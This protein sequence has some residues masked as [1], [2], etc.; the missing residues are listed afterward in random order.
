MNNKYAIILITATTFLSAPLC[1]SAQDSRLSVEKRKLLHHEAQSDAY[2]PN[3]YQ[4]KKVTPAYKYRSK[5]ALKGMS[6]T[7]YTAQV[8]VNGS[9]QNIAG[10]AANEPSIA[11]NPLNPA[12]I[13]IGWRQ[14]DNVTSNF[15]QAGWSFTT[16]G[17]ITWT[18]PGVIEPGIFRSDPV[19]DFDAAGNF[20]YNSLTNSPTYMCK[21]FKSTNGGAAWNTGT[22]A[23]GGDKQWMVIDKTL[24]VGS[25]NI[26]SF[27]TSAYSF[28]TPD[29][30]TRSANGNSSYENCTFADGDPWW[31]TMAVNNAGELFIGSGATDFD[32]LLVAKSVNAQTPASVIAWDTMKVYLDGYLNGWINVNPV[33]LLGQ[34]NIDIDRSNGPGQDNIYILA[35]VTRLSNNDEGD[36]M[37]ARSTNGGQTWSPPVKINDDSSPMNTQW[38][39]TMSV[40]PNGR[41]DAAWLDTRDNPGSD[42]SALY[43]SYSTDQGIT[44]SVNEKLSASFDPHVGYPNQDKMGDYFDMVSDNTGAHLAWANTMNGEQDVYYSFITP[45]TG[46]SV[47]EINPR[48]VINIFPN[49]SSGIFYLTG[50]PEHSQL[51]ICNVLGEKVYRQEISE[52]ITPIDISAQPA[53]IYFLKIITGKRSSSVEKIILN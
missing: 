26:Y 11:V 46:T 17:G 3:A 15:R 9:G 40:A 41:I 39:G 28:C 7:I 31:G 4:N 34:V 38:F 37:F 47:N 10:D 8:N 20:Y 6:S 2:L 43:Y 30:F 12:I 24:G 53:G 51:E 35:S 49:P 45:P 18:F 44:W 1:T 22:D 16:N 29:D 21:V 42:W 25:G 32:S 50:I 27:W 33:G 5:D 36:V 14:F 19:L 48:T 52:E 23:Q 13:A